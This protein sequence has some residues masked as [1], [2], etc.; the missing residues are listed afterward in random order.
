[1]AL[2]TSASRY[3]SEK[4]ESLKIV[5][6][7]L[8]GLSERHIKI[9]PETFGVFGTAPT[10]VLLR[11]LL[12]NGSG[13]SGFYWKISSSKKKRLAGLLWRS[14]RGALPNRPEMKSF[15]KRSARLVMFPCSRSS[16]LALLAC[17]HVPGVIGQTISACIH[18]GYL[19]ALREWL[20]LSSNLMRTRCSASSRNALREVTRERTS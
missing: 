1:L 15:S 10:E 5:P 12:Q 6:E 11:W 18:K 2:P 4:P 8:T 3:Y 9:V 16:R 13:S 20:R 14:R 7:T 17:N 19:V